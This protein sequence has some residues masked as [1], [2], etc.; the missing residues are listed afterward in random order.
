M[1][2]SVA[3]S[4]QGIVS[5]RRL[6]AAVLAETA[7]EAALLLICAVLIDRETLPDGI[8][9]AY[10]AVCLVCAAALGGAIS[11]SRVK[12]GKLIAVLANAAAFEAL[13]ISVGLVFG[14]GSLSGEG[15][16]YQLLCVLLGSITGCIATVKTHKRRKR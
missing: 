13:L 12:Q 14:G 15:T 5:A 16:L 9:K 3:A 11:S 2:K 4:G 7:A 6:A 8:G 10:V 1:Q